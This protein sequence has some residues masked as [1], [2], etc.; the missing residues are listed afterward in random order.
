METGLFILLDSTPWL[1]RGGN[2]SSNAQIGAFY[3]HAN[4]G[5]CTDPTFRLT[6]SV[7]GS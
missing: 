2:N 5:G 6:V 3:F 1:S 4:C 7:I